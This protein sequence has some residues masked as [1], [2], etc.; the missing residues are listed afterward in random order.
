[1]S[2]LGLWMQRLMSQ[3]HLPCLRGHAA[4]GCHVRTMHL[5]KL[6]K[7]QR[8][9]YF[10]VNQVSD[11]SCILNTWRNTDASVGLDLDS[12]AFSFGLLNF[13]HG[14]GQDSEP[15]LKSFNVVFK[16]QEL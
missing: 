16:N 7:S 4:A 11:C 2:S 14:F 15:Y 12:L 1:M 3:A 5:L 10:G 8:I 6:E 9:S 13:G